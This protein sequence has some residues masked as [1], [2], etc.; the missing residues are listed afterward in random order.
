M[1][2]LNEIERGQL[3]QTT[4]ESLYEATGGLKHFPGL[5]KKIIQN[6]AWERRVSRGK[7]IELSSLRELITEKPIRGWGEDPKKI[8]AIIKDDVECLAMYREAM[9]C[10][11]ERNDL[12]NN[13]TEVGRVTGTSASYTV[14]RLQ[15]ESPELFE[16]VKAGELSANAAA[17]QAGF[18]KKMVSVVVG[19]PFSAARS[20]LRHYDADEL[21]EALRAVND[22]ACR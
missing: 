20:L 14:S 1:S 8:E 5:M 13:I 19:D 7:M 6:K 10:Q 21:V 11:G 9:L 12:G 4:V 2:E 17:I 22:G 3:C 15:H 16:K 18:R